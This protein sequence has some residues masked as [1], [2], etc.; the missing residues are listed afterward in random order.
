MKDGGELDAHCKVLYRNFVMQV[1]DFDFAT[2]PTLGW[3]PKTK[4]GS[5]LSGTGRTLG[6]LCPVVEP[7]TVVSNARGRSLISTA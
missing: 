2:Q 6:I 4:C 5:G 7:L 1:R 3:V